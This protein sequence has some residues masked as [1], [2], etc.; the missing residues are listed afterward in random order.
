LNADSPDLIDQTQ[1]FPL[2][3]CRTLSKNARALGGIGDIA[4]FLGA[5][6]QSVPPGL[7][8]VAS[9]L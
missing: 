3:V 7:S 2:A 6:L 4:P 8:I 5:V 1:A 9:G